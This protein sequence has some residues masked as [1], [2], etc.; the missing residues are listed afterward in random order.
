MNSEAIDILIDDYLD[1]REESD[2]YIYRAG[3]GDDTI[4]D[5]G[6]SDNDVLRIEGFAITVDGDGIITGGDVQ[7]KSLPGTFGDL[8]ILLGEKRRDVRLLARQ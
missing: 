7:L 3:D 2:L 5:S 1:G 6:L 4:S 8:R